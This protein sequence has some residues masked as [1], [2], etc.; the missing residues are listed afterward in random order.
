MNIKELNISELEN[1]CADIRETL[2]KVVSKNG[3]HLAPNLGVVELT[4][5]MHYVFNSPE[6]KFL[7]DVGHQSYVHKIL[8]QRKERFETIRKK[9]G[10]SPFCNP[11]ES[12]HD[13]FIAG[14]AGNV[15]S[16][17]LGMAEVEKMNKTNNK[18][19]A[20]VGDAS[21]SN[22]VSMEAF[23]NIG[24]KAENMIV[25]LNDNEMSIGE[26]VGALSKYLSKAMS[27]K[28][29][30]KLK[31]DIEKIIR[32]MLFGNSVAEVIKRLEHSLRYFLY[33]G[34]LFDTLG[35]NYVGPIDGHNL[36]ELI[37]IFR[38]IE[39]MSGPLFIHVKTKKGKGYEFAELNKEKFH[40][41]APFDVCTGE[42]CVKKESYSQIFG[43]TLSNIAREDEDIIAITS[44][45]IKGTGL[46]NFFKEFP[47]RSYDVGIAEEHAVTF[48]GGLAIKG[49]KPVV[50]IY[51]T[52]LQRSYD[53]LIH[54][55]ALQNLPVVFVVD[56]A[57]IV[58]EDG[59]THQ[60]T[61]DISY[62]SSI[63]NF[64]IFAPTTSV[65]FEKCLE[66]SLKESK[67][68][69][70]IRIPRSACFYLK[71]D[72]DFEVGKWNEVKKGKDT[73][74]I[75]TGSML[76]EVFDIEEDLNKAGVFPTIVSATSIIPFDENY[77]LNNI[78]RYKN[79]FVLEE[80]NLAGGFGSM[81][82]NFL[83]EKNILVKV[84]KIGI[85]NIFIEH[86]T[87]N[88]LLEGIGLRGKGLL[89]RIVEGGK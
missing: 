17:G 34:S 75:A 53:Q 62:F 7:W 41:I 10:L 21:L 28:F 86:G 68:P 19:I 89:E 22:G 32:K 6:D 25:I 83:N 16:A 56:R 55:I 77:L 61:F 5:A 42:T 80:N 24:G 20:V 64:Q 78:K 65:E 59:A 43:N 63:P 79:I 84:N 88:E 44:G 50:A 23:N 81:I 45:M 51:S 69:V 39:K 14:H 2:I 54:D 37:S 85:P 8:T 58:G 26:N 1:L 35:Y 30:S 29:Y 57:G 11:K 66:I 27:T 82:V 72:I 4:V 18:V 31:K 87:R 60:G 9:G 73:I 38:N 46:S 70:A 47:N 33:P 76:K 36:S 74:I 3:G 71:K 52:F 67:G 40:G 15:M 49:K 12:E 13:H 48:A